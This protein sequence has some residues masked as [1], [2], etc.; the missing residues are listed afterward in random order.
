MARKIKTITSFRSEIGSFEKDSQNPYYKFHVKEY[1]TDELL[2]SET[3][4][5]QNGAIEWETTHEYD[6]QKRLKSRRTFYAQEKTT[7]K[8][9][10]TYDEKGQKIMDTQYFGDD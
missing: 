2:V 10:F 4:F 1:N 9:V 5:R 3:E 8:M 7:E 6:E